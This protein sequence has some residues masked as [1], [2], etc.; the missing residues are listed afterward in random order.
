MIIKRLV[1]EYIFYNLKNI[2]IARKTTH[3]ADFVYQ[4]IES[5]TLAS[6]TYYGI[7]VMASIWILQIIRKL[8]LHR[9]FA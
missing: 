4:L 9:E 7:H 2:D 1:R 3:E 5:T 8:L 6:E